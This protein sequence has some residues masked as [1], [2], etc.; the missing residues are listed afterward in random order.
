MDNTLKLFVCNETK[1]DSNNKTL[2]PIMKFF[3]VILDRDNH[4]TCPPSQLP[5]HH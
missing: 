2:F 1:K 3:K 4:M 5:F